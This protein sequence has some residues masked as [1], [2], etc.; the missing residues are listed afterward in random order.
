MKKAKLP[1]LKALKKKADI[2][3]SKIIHQTWNETC[4]VCGSTD[5]LQAH[6]FRS[7][8]FWGT[9]FDTSNGILLCAKCHFGHAHRDYE[10]IRRE[11][12]KLHG[13]KMIET[14][15]KKSQTIVKVDREFL[16]KQIKLL[17]K[18]VL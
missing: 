1:S 10:W 5:M 16:E 15:W 17:Q 12:E 13:K 3:W 2:L 6:H 18:E 4:A 14:L 9:R 7:R 8:R 11:F